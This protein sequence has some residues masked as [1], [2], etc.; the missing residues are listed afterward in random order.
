MR[1]GK[2]LQGADFVADFETIPDTFRVVANG[3]VTI[4]S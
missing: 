1:S 3:C 4:I 2:Q